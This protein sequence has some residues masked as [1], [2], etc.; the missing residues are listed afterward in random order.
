[1]L[2]DSDCTIYTRNPD[3]TY[4][5]QTA[6]CHWEDQRGIA[7]TSNNPVVAGNNQIFVMIPLEYVKL[8]I[9]S[10]K[11]KSQNYIV[12]GIFTEDIDQTTSGKFLQS[13]S[14]LTI[15]T[16]DKNDYSI[17]IADNHWAVYAV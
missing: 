4:T 1:M 3:G 7:Y 15:K 8:P 9:V 2:L 16:I 13:I 12:K 11:D 6:E 5:R 14:A 10:A 17:G